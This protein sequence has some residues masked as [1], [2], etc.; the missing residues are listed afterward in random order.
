M[1]ETNDKQVNQKVRK[2]RKYK[3]K[4]GIRKK[5]LIF[6]SIL[7]VVIISVIVF[8]N[9]EEDEEKSVKPAESNEPKAIGTIRVDYYKDLNKVHLKY[10]APPS[11]QSIEEHI[12]RHNYQPATPHHKNDCV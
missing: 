4:D 7:L 8:S 5:L 10:L 11:P 3:L 2:K 6:G 9:P 1:F 12:S